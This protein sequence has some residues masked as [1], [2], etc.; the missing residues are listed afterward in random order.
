[1]D[2]N[3]NQKQRQVYSHITCATDRENVFR[4][5][6]DV[7]HVVVNNSLQRGGLL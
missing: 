2:K 7:Q 3:E 5:F 6:N 1:M 4:V